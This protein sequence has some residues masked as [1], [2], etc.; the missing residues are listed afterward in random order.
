[1]KKKIF[2]KHQIISMLPFISLVAVVIIIVSIINGLGGGYNDFQ[3]KDSIQIYYDNS[4]FTS[5]GYLSVIAATFSPIT[6][7]SYRTSIKKQEFYRQSPIPKNRLLLIR[8]AIVCVMLIAVI[9]LASLVFL[10]ATTFDYKDDTFRVTY[11]ATFSFGKVLLA[12]FMISAATIIQVV[13]SCFIAS[14][15][16]TESTILFASV[17]G[18]AL[19]SF[20]YYAFSHFICETIN[21]F[22]SSA[23]YIGDNDFAFNIFPSGIGIVYSED[24][25]VRYNVTKGST[26]YFDLFAGDFPKGLYILQCIL[27]LTLPTLLA[28]GAVVYLFFEK[29]PSAEYAGKT[30]A[31][32]IIPTIVFHI[33]FAILFLYIGLA[34]SFLPQVTI[35]FYILIIALYYFINCGRNLTLKPDL[36]EAIFLTCCSVPPLLVSSLISILAR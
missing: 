12:I 6:V 18:F 4:S 8:I 21:V 2:I 16:N 3:I 30:K 11:K 28:A 9:I 24:I 26:G 32:S 17:F 23:N 29:E 27:N 15:C 1:M 20:G 7:L 25:L 5:I 34:F 35:P 14:F 22:S 33:S 10:L 19:T 13:I 36:S 31:R